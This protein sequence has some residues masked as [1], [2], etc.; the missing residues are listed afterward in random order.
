MKRTLK[1]ALTRTTRKPKIGKK[2][3]HFLIG[4]RMRVKL[5][6]VEKR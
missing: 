1:K 3:S 5:R 6:R 2:V 4:K